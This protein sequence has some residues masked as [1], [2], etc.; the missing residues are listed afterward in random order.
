[1]DRNTEW[2]FGNI[3]TID[4]KRS[5]FEMVFNHKTTGNAGDL[6][7][8]YVDQDVLPG[9]TH[10][11]RVAGII[12]MSTPQTPVMDVCWADIYF[13]AVPHRILWEHWKEFNGENK[14]G[15]WTQ[16][17]EYTIPQF[18]TDNINQVKTHS[19]L[20]YMGIPI[21]IPNVE[22]SQLPVRAYIKI[23]NDWFRDQNLVAPIKEYEDDATRT[24]DMT[25]PE[26][27]GKCLKIFKK[28]DYFT[29]CLPEAQKGTAVKT[30]LGITAP[31]VGNGPIRITGNNGDVYKLNTGNN[32]YYHI[33]N[34]TQNHLG[35]SENDTDLKLVNNNSGLV[36]DLTKATA[37]TINA[38]RLSFATQNILEKDARGG[39]RYNE[40]IKMHF[41]VTS[42]DGRMQ[43]PEY[44]GGK[45]IPINIDQVI[46]NS[47]T[48]TT[49]PQGYTGAYSLTSDVF[50]VGTKSFTEHSIIIGIIAIRQQHTYQQGL[51]RQWTRK[52]RLDY[53]WPSLAHL[54]EQPVLKKE[55]MA[56]GTD[57][58]EEVFGYQ[59]RWAE[60][61][62][63]PNRISGEMRSTYSKPLD[64]WHYGDKYENVPTL[65]QEF[66]EETDQYINR[67]I[68]VNS[69]IANQF[70]MDIAVEDTAVR[71]MPVYS[72]PG[73]ADHF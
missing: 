22:F 10:K 39:T 26:F 64:I 15:S 23:Y 35:H 29:S 68:H 9:D 46:Q 18:K 55:I 42:P 44:I 54:G 31:I 24:V 41:G 63:K 49:S 8:I 51:A 71:P 11:L 59:E 73:L 62:Y 38:L 43:R 30:P 32:T 7:P 69:S 20:D 48:D 57:K 17:T 58:D 47:S 5:T 45:R 3:P 4:T 37:A 25:K 66:L 50:E 21:D 33:W 13:F 36:A 53:Y 70:I 14:N 27:G 34:E 67:T 12:R 72:I 6:I 60:Y 1:M 28:H 19:I 52:R 65:S 61:K 2:E 56:T 40:V 16:T